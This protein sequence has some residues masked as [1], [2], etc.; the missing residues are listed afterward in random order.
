M[1]K[2]GRFLT[3][4]AK[5]AGRLRILPEYDFPTLSPV[6]F[7]ALT[8]DVLNAEF[9]V[10]VESF[11]PGR[12]KGVDLRCALAGKQ[13]VIQCKHYLRGGRSALRRSVEKEVQKWKDARG[14]GRYILVTSASMTVE[15]K[16]EVVGILQRHLPVTNDDV[17]GRE[18]LNALLL[19]HPEVELRHFK[20]W[21]S[22][23][24]VLSRIIHSGLWNRTEELL[25]SIES[26]AKFYVLTDHFARTTQILEKHNLCVVTGPP[27]VGK[28]I[29]AE[30]VLLA[31][32]KEGWQVVQISEDVKE[33]FDLWNPQQPQIFHY[34]D[35]LGQTD[36]AETTGKNE[37]HRIAQ[38]AEKVRR[39]TPGTKRFVLTTREQILRNA[40]ERSDRIRRARA[41]L[42]PSEVRVEDYSDYTKAL[43]FY[44]HLYFS[45]LPMTDRQTLVEDR[46]YVE[47][48]QHKNY[49]PRIL[50]QTLRYQ[51]HSL[52]ALLSSLRSSLDN[53]SEL[54][55]SSYNHL[56]PVGRRILLILVTHPPKGVDER[57]LRKCVQAQEPHM[58]IQAL[59]VLEGTWLTISNE[60]VHRASL[61][62]PSCRDFLLHKI[63][64]SPA[65]AEA[66]LAD[67]KDIQQALM[68]LR[69]SGLDKYRKSK[70]D[71]RALEA[72]Q[73]LESKRLLWQIRDDMT[74]PNDVVNEG[75]REALLENSVEFIEKIRHL[76]EERVSA[77]KAA[78]RKKSSGYRVATSDPRPEML[79]TVM[80]FISAYG[81]P[82]DIAWCRSEVEGQTAFEAGL[83]DGTV[84]SYVTLA[85]NVQVH[86]FASERLVYDILKRSFEEFYDPSDVEL[87]FDVFDP[88][89]F[90]D[91]M[92]DAAYAAFMR[93][94]DSEYEH[95]STERDYQESRSAADFVE[96]IA[97]KF[98]APVQSLLEDWRRSADENEAEEED[99]QRFAE[100][101]G[102]WPSNRSSQADIG[103]IA[104]LF[105]TLVEE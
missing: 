44:N 66:I 20:L 34:D 61:A 39:A 8:A 38:F 79:S 76:Y 100:S 27:G 105:S 30:M 25:E 36:L 97:E 32:W 98:D 64:G 56:S 1:S 90:S 84:E 74:I 93:F 83:R 50:E 81:S 26:R 48:I 3:G 22:S 11:G 65:I 86:P 49:S 52:A 70:R 19:R 37:D 71:K 53:P 5:Q 87:F 60:S 78:L 62:N 16:E 89:G 104:G 101:P 7:E 72:W 92:R 29:F 46:A 15:F 51:S 47:V 96:G 4:D 10:H 17:F 18:D 58:Y 99:S 42:V 43:I 67:V 12:D 77:W 80:H 73:K 69:Y 88:Q 31:H 82:D 21:T 103:R 85:A 24:A 13:I 9:N 75:L 95:W 91:E 35:F 2:L 94:A 63:N 6:D 54:W 28:S 68:I 14:V 55:A 59:K 41:S 40:Q 45:D 57:D 23:A 33:G 102:S